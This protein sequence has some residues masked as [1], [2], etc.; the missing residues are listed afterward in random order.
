MTTETAKFALLALETKKTVFFIY[1]DKPRFVE[2]HAVGLT[3]KGEA[4]RGW[5]TAGESSRPLPC[6]A[7]F[8]IDKIVMPTA[9]NTPSLAPRPGYAENDKQMITIFGQVP[10]A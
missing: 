2:V 4:L 3:S 7:L 6:W 10:A 1:D 5:Q 8:T 9:I